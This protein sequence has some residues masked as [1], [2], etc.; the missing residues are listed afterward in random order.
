M[1]QKTRKTFMQ[2]DFCPQEISYCVELHISEPGYYRNMCVSCF[3]FAGG[4]AFLKVPV[5]PAFCCIFCT[6]TIVDSDFYCVSYLADSGVDIYRDIC[7]SCGNKSI[8]RDFFET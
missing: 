8:G 6:E 3:M 4:A 7:L 2:C 5:A 1:K